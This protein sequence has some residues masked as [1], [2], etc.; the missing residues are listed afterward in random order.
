MVI[1]DSAGQTGFTYH[2][3]H[4]YKCC[5]LWFGKGISEFHIF[6]KQIFGFFDKAIYS[7]IQ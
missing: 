1:V 2:L 6:E 5:T 3:M 7:F 4:V